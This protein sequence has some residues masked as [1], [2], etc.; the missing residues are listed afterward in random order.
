MVMQG[1]D[2]LCARYWVCS[3]GCI[4]E[5]SKDPGSCGKTDNRQR[6]LNYCVYIGEKALEVM[7][8]R[9]TQ[10]RPGSWECQWGTIPY[11][12]GPARR[13]Q[14]G[15]LSPCACGPQVWTRSI[16]WAGSAT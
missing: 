14:K 11:E 6:N 7:A 4:R 9:K 15:A 1:A 16:G 12:V 8:Q 2:L 3:W 5:Q 13:N 10:G